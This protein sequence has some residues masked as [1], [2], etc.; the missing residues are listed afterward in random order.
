M[1]LKILVEYKCAA[2]KL[3]GI[4]LTT[5]HEIPAKAMKKPRDEPAVW[6]CALMR[7][8]HVVFLFELLDTSASVDEFL[9]TC[10]ERMAH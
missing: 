3:C 7:S 4:Q 1:D 10:K 9:L 8:V 5:V 2:V 6:N